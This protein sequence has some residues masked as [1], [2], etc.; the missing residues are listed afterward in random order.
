MKKFFLTG[1]AVLSL[2]GLSAQN[3]WQDYPFLHRTKSDSVY[4]ERSF[5][6]LSGAFNYGC[7]GINNEFLNKVYRGGFLDSS[8]IESSSGNLLPSNRFGVSTIAGITYGHFL[9]DTTEEMFTI[10]LQQRNSITGRFSDDAFHLAFQG[11]TRYKGEE[12][13]FSRTLFT[14]MNWT[15]LKFGYLTPNPNG[16][17]SF[18]FSLLVGHRYN[19]ADI[20]YGKLYTDSQGL[21][22]TGSV[23][24]DYWSSDTSNTSAFALNGMG[25]SVD[26]TWLYYKPAKNNNMWIAKVDFIDFGFMNWNNKTIHRSIDTTFAWQGVDIS[27]L[28]INP[29]FVSELPEE[30]DFIK[31]D[32][33][34]FHRSIFLPAV[35]R[36]TFTRTFC[37]SR[38][39]TRLAVS[40][41]FW[42]EALPY[43]ALTGAYHFMK[44]KFSASGGIAYGGYARAQVPLKLEWYGLLHTAVSIGTTNALAFIDPASNAGSGAF[45]QLTYCFK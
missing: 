9:N 14:S 5:I 31:S 3:F 32:T 8:F 2:C 20:E 23:S 6:S 26:I 30:S 21:N 4:R 35:I 34:E 18:S 1:I 7:D 44:A 24:G 28:F 22:L 19:Q 36:G 42:S 39:N 29:D 37:A 11:N 16:L 38:V 25:T 15:Q 12:A 45:V 17:V 33:T 40:L 41:P 27:Q 13:D 43:A 10:G